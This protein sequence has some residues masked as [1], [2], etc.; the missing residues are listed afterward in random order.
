MKRLLLALI[1]LNMCHQAEALSPKSIIARQRVNRVRIIQGRI[2]EDRAA[3]ITQ[4]QKQELRLRWRLEKEGYGAARERNR[5]YLAAHEHRLEMKGR[6][7]FKPV[8]QNP[9]R[10]P[11][12]GLGHTFNVNLN[13]GASNEE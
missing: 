11:V 9:L 8:F 2:S 6:V 10:R 5:A 1:I 12:E 3:E 7:V 4:I 13:S